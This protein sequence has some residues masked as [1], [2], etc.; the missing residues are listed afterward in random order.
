M[1][2]SLQ[3][4]AQRYPV[5]RPFNAITDRQSAKAL[6][7]RLNEPTTCRCGKPAI[8]RHGRTG[9]CRGCGDPA[10]PPQRVDVVARKVCPREIECDRKDCGAEKG[11]GC[12]DLVRNLPYPDGI[13]HLT[14]LMDAW[15]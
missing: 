6:R 5:A 7:N 12:W 14:R 15:F 2:T 13:Y 4:T 9:W 1:S 8:Y 3:T 11:E 10:T